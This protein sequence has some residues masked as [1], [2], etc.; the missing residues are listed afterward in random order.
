MEQRRSTMLRLSPVPSI[1]AKRRKEIREICKRCNA[2]IKVPRIE[3][4]K[5]DRVMARPHRH[6]RK[7]E[8]SNL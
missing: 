5:Y 4:E 3:F 8:K 7:R 6:E 2:E 1:D